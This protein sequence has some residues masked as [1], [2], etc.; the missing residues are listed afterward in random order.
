MLAILGVLVT[1]AAT[2]ML[3]ARLPGALQAAPFGWMSEHWLAEQ[4]ASHP[5]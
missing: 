1:L 5:S 2:A 4:R 3:K